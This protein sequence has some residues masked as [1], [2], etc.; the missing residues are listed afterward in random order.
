MCGGAPRGDRDKRLRETADIFGTA[1][2]LVVFKRETS[3]P[4]SLGTF[5]GTFP[6]G[7]FLRV[8][9]PCIRHRFILSEL[10]KLSG[11]RVG[12]HRF[13]QGNTGA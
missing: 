1:L 13:L 3:Y 4:S 6:D 7:C 2:M 9:F 12:V 5:P 10:R 8:R 11:A